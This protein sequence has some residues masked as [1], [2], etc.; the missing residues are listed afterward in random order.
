MK[1]TW[2]LA[3]VGLLVA[4]APAVAT[5]RPGHGGPARLTAGA[6][7]PTVTF[8]SAT[9]VSGRLSGANSG[10]QRVTLTEDPFPYGDGYVNPLTAT[11]GANGS[12]S[13]R[14]VPASNRNYRVTARGQTAFTGVR[15]RMRVSLSVSD[16][17]PAR[18]Q[19]VR[20]SGSVA[21]RHDGR[22]V[23]VQRRSVTGR[24]V[25]V[26]RTSLRPATGD[27]SRYSTGLRIRRT[28]TYR[29]R[30]RADGDHLAGTSRT[31]VLRVP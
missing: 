9:V 28:A 4:A 2:F 22:T 1:R 26:R 12:Y 23:L 15:V 5:H 29:T 7:P 19:R 17:T 10:G 25:T 8:G 24:W 11:T 13:L 3:L 18:G 14:T 16:S 20:F 21:P 30:V 27:R 6:K 31:R